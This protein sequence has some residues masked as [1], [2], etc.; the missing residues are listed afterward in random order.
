MRLYGEKGKTA[1]LTPDGNGLP[2]HQAFF[3]PK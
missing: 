2:V 1:R 3:L